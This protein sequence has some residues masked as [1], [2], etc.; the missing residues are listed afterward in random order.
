MGETAPVGRV[1]VARLRNEP[2]RGPDA[3]GDKPRPY[4]TSKR[5][6]GVERVQVA[7]QE[8]GV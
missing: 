5:L 4:T 2:L 8:P 7:S 3:G 6:S 1:V